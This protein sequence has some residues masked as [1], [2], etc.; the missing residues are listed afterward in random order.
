MLRYF[1]KILFYEKEAALT[2]KLKKK[3]RARYFAAPKTCQIRLLNT[4]QQEEISLKKN[5][6]T[7]QA[8]ITLSNCLIEID[9]T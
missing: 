9:D 5:F 3:K 1:F 6:W 2:H 4:Y 7:S 8:A